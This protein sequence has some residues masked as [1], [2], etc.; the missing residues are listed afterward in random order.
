[1]RIADW[2]KDGFKSDWNYRIYKH[3]I[4]NNILLL[5]KIVKKPIDSAL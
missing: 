5:S 3:Q 2:K 4:T 1:M